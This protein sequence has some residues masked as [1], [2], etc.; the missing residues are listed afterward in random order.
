MLDCVR[1]EGYRDWKLL[2]S[3][4]EDNSALNEKFESNVFKRCLWVLTCYNISEHG[5]E[6][7]EVAAL[8]L[9]QKPCHA[10]HLYCSQLII[11]VFQILIPAIPWRR[12]NAGKHQETQVTP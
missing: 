10:P 4:R 12:V 11:N 7:W 3:E 8:K 5:L 2:K 6:S 1:L 9:V